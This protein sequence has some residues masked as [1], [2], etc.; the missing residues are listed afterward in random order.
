M[1]FPNFFSEYS[2]YKLDDDG[3]NQTENDHCRNWKIKSKVFSFDPY[4]TR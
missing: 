3:N 4:V 2:F 1:M